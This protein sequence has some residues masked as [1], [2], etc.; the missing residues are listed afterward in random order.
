MNNK[1]IEARDTVFGFLSFFFF[2]C[3]VYQFFAGDVARGFLA[4]GISLVCAVYSGI[5]IKR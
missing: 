3:T 5:T 1:G 2:G 4:L